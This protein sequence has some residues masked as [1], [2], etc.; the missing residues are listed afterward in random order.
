MDHISFWVTFVPLSLVSVYGIVSLFVF[1]FY[2]PKMQ[3]QP[4]L[5]DDRHTSKI[6]NTW[7]RYWWIW[8]VSPLFKILLKSKLTPNQISFLGLILALLSCL[9]FAFGDLWIGASAFS[10]GGWF[11]VLGGSMD[12]MDGWVARKTGQETESGAFFDS[13]LDRIAESFV[14][15]GLAWHYRGS[16]A[17]WVV[18]FAFTGSMMTSYAKCRGDKMGVSYGGGVMQRPERVVYLG[19]GGIFAPQVAMLVCRFFPQFFPDFAA[20]ADFIY[21]VPLGFVA[22]MSNIT[23]FDRIRTVMRLLDE[24]ARQKK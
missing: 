2:Y 14:L 16:S 4:D 20:A 9:S 17:L 1:S 19:V 6:L 22:I 21:L 5:V 11:M 18:M 23:S 12:F 8:T 13:C 24:R 3:R 15:A 10:V 7:I